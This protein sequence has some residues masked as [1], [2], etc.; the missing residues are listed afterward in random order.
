MA[1]VIRADRLT[2]RYGDVDAL[3]GVSL[4]VG[5]GEL[6]GLLG[7]NSA[8]KTTLIELL[9][10]VRLPT[11]GSAEVCGGNPRDPATRRAIGV[12]PQSTALPESWRVGE[13]I[14]FVRAHYR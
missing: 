10:G 13:L 12:V 2:R 1:T 9:A 6:V 4:D 14:D 3:A 5:A 11:S 8:G 7:P